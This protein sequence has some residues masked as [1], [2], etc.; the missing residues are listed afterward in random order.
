MVTRVTDNKIA[1]KGAKHGMEEQKNLKV[2]NGE[3]ISVKKVGL[4]FLSL[5]KK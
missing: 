4:R 2:G 3:F 5:D 1:Q